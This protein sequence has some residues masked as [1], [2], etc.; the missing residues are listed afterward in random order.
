[1]EGANES[2]TSAS[3]IYS[4]FNDRSIINTPVE[5]LGAGLRSL[6]NSCPSTEWKSHGYRS[7]P[8][9]TY[10]SGLLDIAVSDRLRA[11]IG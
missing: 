9:E 6:F 1:M 2:L 4:G 8:T 3:Q 10:Q 11:D 7:R 5:S